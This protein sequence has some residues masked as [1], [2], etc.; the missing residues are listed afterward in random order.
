MEFT[1]AELINL[2][3]KL[4]E[5]INKIPHIRDNGWAP[6]R[7]DFDSVKKKVL[8]EIAYQIWEKEG[9]PKNNDMAIWLQAENTWNLIR[10]GWD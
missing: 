1:D 5:E 8:C 3:K 4:Y 7:V 2:R 6:E 9:K 10:Y